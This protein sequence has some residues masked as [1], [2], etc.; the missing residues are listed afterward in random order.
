[1]RDMEI[2]T[3]REIYTILF[4][5]DKK[6]ELENISFMRGRNLPCLVEYELTPKDIDRA[7]RKANI[8]AVKNTQAWWKKQ[9]EDN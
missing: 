1:M 5:H 3:C 6:R 8:F 4:N 7:N 9:Y 2:K